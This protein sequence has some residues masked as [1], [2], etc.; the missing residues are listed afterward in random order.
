MSYH[1]ELEKI[2]S[3]IVTS[4]LS[5]ASNDPSYFTK[6]VL[7]PNRRDLIHTHVRIAEYRDP[8]AN[9]G[10]LTIGTKTKN[11]SIRP[12]VWNG[13]CNPLICHEHN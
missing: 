6:Q 8:V 4:H 3:E 10:P 7:H 1:Q 2:Q 13:S 5:S 11:E 9:V 12:A